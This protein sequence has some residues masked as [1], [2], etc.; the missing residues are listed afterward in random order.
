M[1]IELN[2]IPHQTE[3]LNTIAEV[4]KDVEITT[5][6]PIHQ[7]PI[8][9]LNDNQIQENIDRIWQDSNLN[10]P[11]NMQKRRKDNKNIL[12]I[13]AKLETG[14]GKTYIYTRLMYE[15]NERYGFNK[16]VILVP[17]T[18]IKEGTKNFIK[19]DY[20]K[21]HFSDLYPTK[22]LSLEVLNA[23]PSQQS[24]RKMF[25]TSIGN[26][27]R[28]NRQSKNKINA[29]LMSDSM[30]LSKKTMAKDDYDQTLFGGSTQPYSALAETKPIVIIDEPHRFK[31]KN[32]AFQCIE[33]E[34][35]P[36]S[37]I[38]FG[39]TFPDLPEKEGK[40]YNNL[41]YDLGPSKAFNDNL[42]KGVAVQTIEGA[43]MEDGKIKLTNMSY[44]PRTCTFRNEKTKRVFT[45][46]TGS[47]LNT[48]DEQFGGIYIEN[49]WNTSHPDITKGVTL[50]NGQV[51]QADD[52]IY[53]SVYGETYQ[54]LMLKQAINNHIRKEKE[55]FYRENKI[56]SLSLFFIESVYSY[57]RG[58]DPG[59]L[60]VTFEDLLR[61]R[62]KEEIKLLNN[63]ETLTSIDVEYKDY[64]LASLNDISKTNGGY[65]SVDNSTNDKDIQWEVEKILREK[66][67]LLSFKNENN[68]WNT[69]RFIFSK[70]TL[71]EGWDNPNVFQIAKLRSSGS[72]VSKLQEVGRGLRL[73]VDEYGNRIDDE[74]FHLTYLVDFSERDFAQRLISEVNKEVESYYNLSGVLSKA[75]QERQTTEENLFAELLSKNLV[76]IEKNVKEGKWSEL[77]SLYPELNGGTEQ[78][79]IVDENKDNKGKVKIRPNK[80]KEIQNLWSEI[81]EKYYL[82]MDDITDEDLM[83]VVFNILNEKSLY[84]KVIHHTKEQKTF[85]DSNKVGVKEEY[86][87]HHFSEQTLQYNEFVKRIQ[88]HTGVS[89]NI[90]HK[91]MIKHSKDHSIPDDYFNSV[92]LTNFINAF[93][94][95]LEDSFI[96]RFSYQKIGV[97]AKETALTNADGTM[98]DSII[99]GNLGIKRDENVIIP[100]N[101]LYDSFVYD[102]PKERETISHSDI[103]EV[104][105]FGKIPR[106]SIQ[107]PLYYGGTTS[108]DFMFIL[109]KK[110]G[111]YVVNFVV[112]TKDIQNKNKTRKDEDY[113]IES[114][115]VFFEALKEEGLPIT[116]KKQ[117]KNDDIVNMIKELVK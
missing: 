38:R 14:T 12:G 78:D 62:L 10:I 75:A 20:S 68:E 88:N 42:V 46:E 80:F 55:N 66:E 109:K 17:S 59:P 98:K 77:I 4:F 22:K 54:E 87:D 74:Q 82:K 28:G 53:S 111:E 64:L 69:M 50:S 9:N 86:I 102:S 113:R 97:E 96:K 106:R 105:V 57:R 71:R 56:K 5:E 95:W 29:L 79:K 83:E 27:I 94:T 61:Q 65:F 41:V 76:D 51:L 44:R 13:D 11:R 26:F 34:L 23:Q 15:L 21:R 19:A 16:F 45:L 43:S 108:P 24:G 93:Q 8:I 84:K 35:K 3:V 112:E 48:I 58:K 30:L 7:N 37:I 117:M 6:N 115:K 70:W 36:Q 72:E 110:N 39:A 63:K 104:V 67:S 103:E 31:R 107:I 91:A 1:A 49:I 25:P 92:T 99:Q 90:F 81:N 73:P 101:F 60:R 18:P 52:I 47:F 32:K 89:P 116:F 33:E 100:E 2:I 85:K 114:A 40:D